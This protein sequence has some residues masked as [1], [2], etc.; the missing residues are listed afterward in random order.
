METIGILAKKAG[1]DPDLMDSIT[2]ISTTTI[3]SPF[4]YTFLASILFIIFYIIPIDFFISNFSISIVIRTLLF[5]VT[6]ELLMRTQ[7]FQDL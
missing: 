5:A 4:K 6:F 2:K 3:I 7:W 1:L